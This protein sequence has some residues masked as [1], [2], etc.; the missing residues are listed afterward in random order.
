M[1]KKTLA[2]LAC[3][4]L[5]PLVVYFLWPS[6]ESRIR[7]L[8]REGSRAIEQEKIDDVMSKVALTYSDEYGLT[9]LYIREGMER[10]FQRLDAIQIEYE[11]TS[12]A[13]S[14]TTATAE[15][16][17]RVIATAGSDTGYAV[18]EA[19]RPVKMRFFLEKER[20]SWRVAKTA[21]LPLNF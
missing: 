11:I 18:G 10:V 9:Y 12:L 1:S 16:D 2:L 5:A 17:V 7:A 6:D 3:L 20:G 13:I 8:F 21:G 19:A 4:I 14:D 15:L